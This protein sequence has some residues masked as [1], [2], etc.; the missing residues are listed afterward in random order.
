MLLP[1][2]FLGSFLAV[3]LHLCSIS[4]HL[5][6]CALPSPFP[7]TPTDRPDMPLSKW[8]GL[9]P[10]FL[11]GIGYSLRRGNNR[12]S[13]H[14]RRKTVF[15]HASLNSPHISF[16]LN[17]HVTLQHSFRIHSKVIIK[18][19]NRNLKTL[20]SPLFLSYSLPPQNSTLHS[21]GSLFFS[22]TGGGDRG[23]R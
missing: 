11:F 5:S 8:E 23:G 17:D 20:V 4:G 22:S 9:L 21:W 1:H 18:D 15:P 10:S 2:K 3:L 14:R 13:E 6:K 7:S 19:L 16:A 12:L